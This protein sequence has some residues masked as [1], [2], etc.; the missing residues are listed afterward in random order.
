MYLQC[1]TLEFLQSYHYLYIY[2]LILCKCD[3]LFSS[4]TQR[5][6]KKARK[7]GIPVGVKCL[8]DLSRCAEAL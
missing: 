3:N 8:H 7:H 5:G 1:S 4:K 6:Q 2:Y